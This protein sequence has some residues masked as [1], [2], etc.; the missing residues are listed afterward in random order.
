[1]ASELHLHPDRL[2]AH[3]ASAAALADRLRTA[4]DRVPAA[5]P[6]ADRLRSA[7]LRHAAEL[8]ELGLALSV[9][10]SSTEQGDESV[11]RSL[12]RLPRNP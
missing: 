12:A 4:G 3:A 5:E 11:A 10:A 9:A 7:V 8:A 2:R 1:M 6:D